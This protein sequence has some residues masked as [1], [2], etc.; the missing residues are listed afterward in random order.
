MD[1]EMIV[2][3]FIARSDDMAELRAARAED[4]P[5]EYKGS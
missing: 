3:T 1:E 5:P 2:Q 4:R